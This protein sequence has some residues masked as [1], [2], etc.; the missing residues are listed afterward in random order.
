MSNSNQIRSHLHPDGLSRLPEVLKI[1]P[2]SRAAWYRGIQQ[3]IYPK[4]VKL[5]GGRTSAW[6]NSDL[7][8][9]IEQLGSDAA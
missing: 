9:L 7:L 6:R 5:S 4:P 1:I 3:G 2:V 8:D